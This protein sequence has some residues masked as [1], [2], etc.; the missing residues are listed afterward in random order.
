MGNT[1]SE[2]SA[3][4]K[5]AADAKHAQVRLIKSALLKKVEDHEERLHAM[6]VHGDPHLGVFRE[7]LMNEVDQHLK[8]HATMEE[9]QKQLAQFKEE[10]M[11]KVEEHTKE[12]HQAEDKAKGKASK[13]EEIRLVSALLE[14]FLNDKL[15]EMEPSHRFSNSVFLIFSCGSHERR[16]AQ[17]GR[18]TLNERGVVSQLDV[19]VL[20]WYRFRAAKEGS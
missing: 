3:K 5:A 20:L 16:N 15:P 7:E 10:L 6:E 17:K 8:E 18:R 19:I 2:L 12:I 1:S 14:V 4:E 11:A 9:E 13:Q